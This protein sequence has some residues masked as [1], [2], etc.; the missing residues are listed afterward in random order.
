MTDDPFPHDFGAKIQPSHHAD[1]EL[2]GHNPDHVPFVVCK[3]HRSSWFV[4]QRRDSFLA[5]Q[6]DLFITTYEDDDHIL[7]REPVDEAD[8]YEE[9]EGIADGA[10]PGDRLTYRSMGRR[11]LAKEIEESVQRQLTVQQL[12]D[13]RNVHFPL[14]PC[15]MGWEDWHFER[16]R[17]L[18]DEMST[19]VGFD[20][21]QYNSKYTLEEDVNRL[22]EV[23]APERIF[24]NGC[25]SPE[26]L[27]RLP[28]SVVACSGT[29]NIRKKCEDARGNV[30][31]DWLPE[32]VE[33]R[34][35]ELYRWQSS[36]DQ[37]L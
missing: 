9:L 4:N 26:R 28:K 27:W 10:F 18:L 5:P 22:D 30:Q 24:I 29:Y 17:I 12:L 33:K 31:R 36:L 37:Y 6:Q 2:Y 34:V 15:I 25:V 7:G 13:D 16:C 35:D 14:Y 1:Q 32:V 20:A 3:F 8:R 11:E 19:S 23:L 21:T